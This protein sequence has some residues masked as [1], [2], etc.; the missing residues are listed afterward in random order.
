MQVLHALMCRGDCCAGGGD[1]GVANWRKAKYVSDN[2]TCS[3]SEANGAPAEE[4][5][6]V[7]C[8]PPVDEMPLVGGSPSAA[9]DAFINAVMD[10]TKRISKK[11]ME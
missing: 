4:T 3:C 11:R 2:C 1:R 10:Q 5:S 7:E 9:T 6:L 8:L